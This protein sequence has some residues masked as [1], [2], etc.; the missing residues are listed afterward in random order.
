[1]FELPEFLTLARQV[2]QVLAGKTVQSGSLGNS[3]HKFVWYNRT[4]EEFA[5]LTQGKFIG[6][7]YTRGKWLFIPLEPGYLLTF[8]ECGGRILHHPAGTPLPEK[9][10]L[11]I[12][13]TDGDA[14]SAMTQMW[15]AMELYEKGTELQRQYIKGMRPTPVD[16][17]FTP[18]YFSA[19]VQET[20]GGKKRSVKGL[21]T[22]DAL[23]PGLGNAITQDILFLAR[24]HPR[25]PVDALD[26]VEIGRLYTA[27][28]DTIREAARL[29]GR[30]D[31][32][33]LFNQPGGYQRLMD[34]NAVSRP[35]PSCGGKV[36]KIQYLG[37]ACYFCPSC[38]PLPVN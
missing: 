7:A 13:F 9:Y 34:H 4:P 5:A 8:G 36:E 14:L 37:G 30:N 6:T 11:L 33:D 25:H 32:T 27:I 19:L 26:G 1:M 21:L 29:G 15:G 24:L 12:H 16:P 2:N 38:Q 3:P 35:C 17:E 23:I 18:E 28:V 31:E 20:A 22:Q 10:H